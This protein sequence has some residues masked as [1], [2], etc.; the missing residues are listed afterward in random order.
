MDRK[1]GGNFFKIPLP[2]PNCAST[3][4]IMNK[5]RNMHNTRTIVNVLFIFFNKEE[6]LKFNNFNID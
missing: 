6:N 3:A 4:G 5:P 2:N 1:I